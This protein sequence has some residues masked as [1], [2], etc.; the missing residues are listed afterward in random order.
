MEDLPLILY[1]YTL[2]SSAYAGLHNIEAAMIYAIRSNMMLQPEI[3]KFII[4]GTWMNNGID[5]WQMPI[6]QGDARV[7]GLGHEIHSYYPKTLL[8][9]QFFTHSSVALVNGVQQRFASAVKKYREAL[10]AVR[11]LPGVRATELVVSTLCNI[12]N[13]LRKNGDTDEA[14][15]AYIER[16]NLVVEEKERIF[17]NHKYVSRP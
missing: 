10:S 4:S 5:D 12:E 17:I 13:N 14:D 6:P 11:Q 15:K 9:L 2:V 1:Y 8:M 16:L 3:P 7:P